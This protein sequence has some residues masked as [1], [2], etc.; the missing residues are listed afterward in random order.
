MF[1]FTLS[2][3]PPF[4]W[5]NMLNFFRHRAIPGVECVTDNAYTRS[6]ALNDRQG[7]L[8]L[9]PSSQPNALQLDIELPFSQ[10]LLE[11]EV[12]GRVRKIMDL[13][14]PMDQ[15][16]FCLSQHDLFARL[17]E[18]H[19]GTRLPGCWDP[20]EFAVR[21]IL[22]Q[23]ISVKAATT[24]AGRIVQQY[25]SLLPSGAPEGITH[26]FPDS[27][28]LAQ[29]SFDQIGLTRTRKATLINLT[30]QVASGALELHC[31]EGL[32]D[33]VQRICREPGIGPWTAHYLAMRGLSQPDAFPASDLGIIKMLSTGDD[34]LKPRQIEAMAEDWRPWRAYAAIYLWQG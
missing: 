30:R 27:S 13:D 8:R 34:V 10:K 23:Q 6:I 4:N 25:G 12:V 3:K 20:F 9:T 5:A 15:I 26:G 2:Y 18:K 32:D 1:T 31:N 22:G 16:E 21:A 17:I 29:A 11:Q 33:F 7:W 19:K 14:A 24:L 28:V